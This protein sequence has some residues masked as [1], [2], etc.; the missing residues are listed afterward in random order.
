VH[1]DVKSTNVLLRTPVSA[2]AATA[3]GG[4]A[5]LGRLEPLLADFGEAGDLGGGEAA[6]RGLRSSKG[7]A[8][9]RPPL[10]LL[11]LGGGHGWD[12][13]ALGLLLLTF[14]HYDTLHPY[15]GALSGQAR[16][17][18]PAAIAALSQPPAF[19]P[20]SLSADARRVL[21]SMLQPDPARRPS[22]DRL[23]QDA[24]VAKG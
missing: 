12:V 14:A 1:R 23:L 7:L 24:W 15:F 18:T 3:S 11:G 9:M 6:R 2:G 16:A 8:E 5:L 22:A 21:L 19:V 17:M 10:V 20:A 13:W 4:L